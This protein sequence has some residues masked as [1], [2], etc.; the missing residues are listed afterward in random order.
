MDIRIEPYREAD[1]P[2]VC[3]GLMR[4]QAHE[5]PLSDTRVEATEEGAQAYL[6]VLLDNVQSKR[7]AFLCA[8]E[9]EELVGF[10]VGWVESEDNVNETPDSTTYG[11]V[12]DAFV[13]EAYRGAGVFTSLHAAIENHFA[14]LPDVHRLRIGVLTNN[15]EA[16]AAYRAVGYGDY[17][18]V[19]Q[20]AL[21]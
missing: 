2:A 6:K 13:F 5:V 8:Y 17:E 9:G 21:Q 4:L 16:V 19:L 3:E 11:Y 15:P 18:L 20:K 10:I 14:Q 1:A 7:G 12:S